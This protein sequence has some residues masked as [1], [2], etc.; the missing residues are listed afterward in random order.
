MQDIRMK[1]NINLSINDSFYGSL[2]L[3]LLDYFIGFRFQ[4]NYLMRTITLRH[5]HE[6]KL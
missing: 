2:L 1:Q 4:V 3:K 6:T 5:S